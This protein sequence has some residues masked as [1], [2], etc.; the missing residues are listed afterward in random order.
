[1][2]IGWHVAKRLNA[3][4]ARLADETARSVEVDVGMRPAAGHAESCGWESSLGVAG[5]F[6]DQP[7]IADAASEL[8]RDIFGEHKI[9]SRVAFGA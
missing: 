4:A 1:M 2:P 8:P 3:L 7:K 6:I 5:D 9:S